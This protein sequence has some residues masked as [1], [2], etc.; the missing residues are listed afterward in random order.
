L[1]C[2]GTVVLGL[3]IDVTPDDATLEDES[4]ETLPIQ[5]PAPN[6]STEP[7]AQKISLDRAVRFPD[8]AALTA[9][10]ERACIR[11]PKSRTHAVQ[12]AILFTPAL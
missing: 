2:I 8:S 7:V 1:K 11:C 12:I 6:V 4:T 3:R 9:Q 5:A 10:K